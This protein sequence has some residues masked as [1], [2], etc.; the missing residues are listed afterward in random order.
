MKKRGRVLLLI[1]GF[2]VLMLWIDIGGK[3]N[4]AAIT[5]V[6]VGYTNPLSRSI[7]GMPDARGGRPVSMADEHIALLRATN[8]GSVP[9]Q[10]STAI[11]DSSTIAILDP[12]APSPPWVLK[13]GESMMIHVVVH[14]GRGP[15]STEL[16]YSRYGFREK[17][18]DWTWNENTP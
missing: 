3:R 5:V 6:F 10:V 7:S 12:S 17:F 4:D 2:L 14:P 8:T 13:A 9:V 1:G 15:W 18:Y 11:W 16:T